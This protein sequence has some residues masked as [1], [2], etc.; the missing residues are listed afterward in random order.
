MTTMDD[1]V[2]Q[3]LVKWPNVPHCHG[4]L[5]LDARGNWYLRDDRTQA[6]GPF[7]AE[8]GSM[9]RHD[10]LIDFIHRNYAPD[11]EGRW[12][13]QNGPQ[14]VYVELEAAPWIWRVDEDFRIVSH[15]GVAVAGPAVAGA[16]GDAEKAGAIGASGTDEAPAPA[17]TVLLDEAGRL[18]V[19]TSIGLGLV[20]TQDVGLAADAIEQGRWPAPEEVRAADLP[21]RFGHV[22]S[23]AAHHAATRA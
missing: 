1:I 10:K 22:L 9:L 3:A 15:T 11:D 7:P 21:A 16:A 2:K 8:K 19:A 5:G 6:A 20:H 23:P 12:F 18:Y 14:R 17:V 13:F 4:W